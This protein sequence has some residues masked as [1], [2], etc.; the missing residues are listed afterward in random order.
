MERTVARVNVETSSLHH[1]FLGEVIEHRD[2]LT[3]A[4]RAT[5]WPVHF[6]RDNEIQGEG[7]PAEYFYQIETGAVRSYKLLDDGR[8]QIIAFHFAGDVIELDAGRRHRSSAAATATCVI[9]V[10]K[11]TAIVAMALRIPDLATEIWRRTAS[12]LQFAQEH[13]LA[14]GRRNA[15]ERMASFLL[16][17]AD[18]S[19]SSLL[20]ELPMTRRDIADYL[21]LTVETVA[22][23][24]TQLESALC[25]QAKPSRDSTVQSPR[26]AIPVPRVD[27]RMLW[28]GGLSAL[29]PRLRH[30]LARMT[31][32]AALESPATLFGICPDSRQP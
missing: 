4:F 11:R 7:E 16:E 15:E 23:T 21:G 27:L 5:G 31:V 18:R 3:Q 17:M 20:V 29:R 19:S 10:A 2:P 25:H 13:L 8:R 32:S 1:D 22:R 6:K 12:D 26:A 24:L 30:V 28:P 9:R 14:L